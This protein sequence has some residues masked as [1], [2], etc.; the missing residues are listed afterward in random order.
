MHKHFQTANN[1]Q[2]FRDLQKRMKEKGAV[3]GTSVRALLQ[4]NELN[5][6][7]FSSFSSDDGERLELDQSAKRKFLVSSCNE[8]A[9]Q[10]SDLTLMRESGSEINFKQ[11]QLQ[12][13]LR[14]DP[15]FADIDSRPYIRLPSREPTLQFLVNVILCTTDEG[16][17]SLLTIRGDKYLGKSKFID[18]VVSNAQ[19]QSQNSF[20]VL[21][22][23]RSSNTSMISLFPFREIV[24][25]AL[26][27]CDEK[28]NMIGKQSANE[29]IV[30]GSLEDSDSTIVQRLRQ[31]KVL[32]KSDQLMIS[33]ILPDVMLESRDLLSLLGGR[34]PKAITQD[35]AATLFKLLI[36]L[37]PVLLVFD[38]IDGDGGLD[39]SSLEL[40]EQ[41]ILVSLTSCPQMIPIL[42]SRQPLY[43]PEPL[44]NVQ[45]DTLL[46][47]MTKEDSEEY[48]RAIFDPDCLDRHMTVDENVLD[49]IHARA[50][51]CPL[52]LE[53]LVLWAQNKEI[54]EIDETRNAVAINNFAP[55]ESE[56]ADLLPMTLYEE[57]L[58]EINNLSH[59][60][61]ESLKLACCMGRCCPI[62]LCLFLFHIY[63]LCAHMDFY[64]SLI[65]NDVLFFDI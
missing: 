47:S 63:L 32:D 11:Q 6:G 35:T 50:N 49:V 14:N 25:S 13:R 58:S 8:P 64:C 33:R 62:H 37:Q 65:R 41:L 19:E 42:I 34:S 44:V 22:S 46:S 45:V 28:T 38:A 9:N 18:A 12:Q 16:K 7:S 39:A 23:E 26:R 20:T 40:L 27:A 1:P 31:R 36:P 30:V 17:P 51:G 5:S 53:R 29:D 10:E 60:E 3:T 21:K 54:I 24:S 57:V 56:L 4:N 15:L 52:F 59:N 61:L 43:I 48:I 2:S 55:R